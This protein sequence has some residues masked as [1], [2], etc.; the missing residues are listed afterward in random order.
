MV[1]SKRAWFITWEPINQD[2][3]K[4]Y[5]VVTIL[6]YRVSDN[7]VKKILEQ[8]YVD[9]TFFPS[10]RIAYTKSKKSKSH[11]VQ[12]DEINGISWWGRMTCGHNPYLYA[13]QVCNI[14]VKEDENGKEF[15]EWEEIKKPIVDH[16]R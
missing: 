2:N 11:L 14:R 3:R 15:F 8:L 12:F 9:Q 1:K 6:N 13:R 10:E 4:G 16:I 7:T 5:N